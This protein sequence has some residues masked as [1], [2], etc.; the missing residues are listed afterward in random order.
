MFDIGWME[1]MI[2]GMVM[3]LVVGPKELPGLLRTIGKY[4]GMVKRQ[5]NEFRAQFDE[6]IKESEFQELKKDMESLG[7][8]TEAEMRDASNSLNDDLAEF[9]EHSTLDDD[10]YLDVDDKGN[11]ASEGGEPVADENTPSEGAAV[12]DT[13]SAVES[14]GK[15]DVEPART[16]AP[17]NGAISANGHDLSD[18]MPG[19]TAGTG[20][21]AQTAEGKSD[22]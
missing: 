10:D 17:A 3:L 13:T 11:W 16:P 12:T 4:A 7:E 6:A 2:V 1:L 9:D 19:D 15:N 5:A 20:A 21:K 22:A 8:E 14:A 18:N